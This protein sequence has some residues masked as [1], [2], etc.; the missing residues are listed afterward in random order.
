MSIRCGI[1]NIW[2]CESISVSHFQVVNM[3]RHTKRQLS[4]LSD[5]EKERQPE[6]HRGPSEYFFFSQLAHYA[7]L[8]AHCR[9]SPPCLCYCVQIH[10]LYSIRIVFITKFSLHSCEHVN[11]FIGFSFITFI[12]E[13]QW[14]KTEKL[15]IFEHISHKPRFRYDESTNLGLY[16]NLSESVIQQ[17]HKSLLFMFDH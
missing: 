16:A 14:Y 3:H 5:W 7:Y 4:L 9:R 11:S 8:F 10:V 2:L 12:T 1:S 13:V 15:L 6:T 17:Q